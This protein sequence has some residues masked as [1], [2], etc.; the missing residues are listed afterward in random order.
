M[1]AL[2]AASR[3]LL[4]AAAFTAF[5][6]AFVTTPLVARGDAGVVPDPVAPV[7]PQPASTAFADIVP[8]R[9][10]FAGGD[11]PAAHAT[12][13]PP[14]APV[15]MPAIPPLPPIP[16]EP[17]LPHIPA[18]LRALPA[19]AGA[20]DGA[21]PFASGARGSAVVTAV[22]T[23][24]HPYALVDEA[25][26]TRVLTGG[27]RLAHGTLLP[28]ARASGPM[29]PQPPARASAPVVV[30]PPPSHPISGGR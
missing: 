14:Q 28:V 24:P 7:A 1:F 13:S 3:T 27:V 29:P 12:G 26:T 8:R 4:A 6:G 30:A 20:G 15:A 2:H 22:I 17:L 19:N 10:P 25:G 11:A 18:A 5:G 9:D 21:F 23:G 16:G